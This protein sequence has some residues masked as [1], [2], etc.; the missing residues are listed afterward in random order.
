MKFNHINEQSKRVGLS[1]VSWKRVPPACSQKRNRAHVILR[2]GELRL[3][4][5]CP[6]RTPGDQVQLPEAGTKTEEED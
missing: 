4:V 2:V 5:P 1:T 6:G 3:F